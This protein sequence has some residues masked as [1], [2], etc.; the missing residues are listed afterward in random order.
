M[1]ATGNATAPARGRGA[2][3]ISN[4]PPAAEPSRPPSDAP[5]PGGDPRSGDL[6]QE[7]RGGRS[8]DQVADAQEGGDEQWDAEGSRRQSSFGPRS[9]ARAQ[10]CVEH[11]ALHHAGD[12]GSIGIRLVSFVKVRLFYRA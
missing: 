8:P 4:A 7:V 10:H 9:K 2:S 12:I 11:W 1:D 3:R 6:G 5:D